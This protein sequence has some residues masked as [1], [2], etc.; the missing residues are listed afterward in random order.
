MVYQA[1][2]QAFINS[3]PVMT[4]TMHNAV[5]RLVGA[6]EGYMGPCYMQPYQMG[7]TP[8]ESTT[9]TITSASA[10]RSEENNGQVT[11]QTTGV[12]SLPQINPVFSTTSPV[13]TRF[14]ED[15][16]QDSHV[17]GIQ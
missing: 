8:T 5:L 11:S 17:D 16:P 3:A 2:G 13:T 15:L 9:E 7:F 1:V 14:K 4:N 10:S 12:T 6:N